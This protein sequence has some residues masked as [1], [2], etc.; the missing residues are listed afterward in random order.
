MTE[1]DANNKQ[2]PRS[3]NAKPP[4]MNVKIAI[5]GVGRGYQAF[6]FYCLKEWFGGLLDS[7]YSYSTSNIVHLLVLS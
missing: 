4:E 5:L 3:R 1:L 6:K 2:T 7:Y